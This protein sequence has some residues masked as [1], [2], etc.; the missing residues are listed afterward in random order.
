MY[1]Y[2]LSESWLGFR[3]TNLLMECF[4]RNDLRNIV[5]NI[6]LVKNTKHQIMTI[7]SKA[8]LYNRLL[9]ITSSCVPEA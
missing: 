4:S 9:Q 8:S 6:I 7:S 3:F 2:S 1:V 5:M